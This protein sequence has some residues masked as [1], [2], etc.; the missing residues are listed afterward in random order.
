[1]TGKELPCI[2]EAHSSAGFWNGILDL[3]SPYSDC[4]VKRFLV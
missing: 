3:V 4:D 2:S 1:M